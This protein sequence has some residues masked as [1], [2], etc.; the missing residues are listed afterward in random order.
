MK[1][2][3]N[4]AR[5]C[6]REKRQTTFSRK[7][8]PTSMNK[9][10]LSFDHGFHFHQDFLIFLESKLTENSATSWFSDELRIFISILEID[11]KKW[12]IWVWLMI[13]CDFSCCCHLSFTFSCRSWTL[14]GRQKIIP[15][16]HWLLKMS[17][18]EFLSQKRNK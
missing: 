8:L 14:I 5:W 7:I 12:F 16:F 18:Y 17:G 9:T 3:N 11:F 15:V 2:E 1:P 4:L 6:S 10:F 13:R